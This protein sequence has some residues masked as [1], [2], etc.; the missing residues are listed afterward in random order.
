MPKFKKRPV[1]IEA[2]QT[3]E[4]L[5][6]ETLEGTMVANPTDWVIR[7]VTNETY[8]C[9]D[10]IFRKTYIREF[11]PENPNERKHPD[12][13][14]EYLEW[15][16]ELKPQVEKAQELA[17]KH[18][19]GME[20]ELVVSSPDEMGSGWELH[21]RICVPIS[22]YARETHERMSAMDRD[23]IEANLEPDVDYDGQFS[24]VIYFV[25]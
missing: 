15:Y 25:D 22:C 11:E 14:E 16:S 7:G 20:T 23:M 9:R 3:Q 4:R 21:M 5:E 8:P 18:F 19:E 12:L 13:V 1:V 10:D 2:Y 24:Y 17:K 6:I